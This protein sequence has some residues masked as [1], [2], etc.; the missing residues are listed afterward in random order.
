MGYQRVI[1]SDDTLNRVQDNIT[2]TVN[3]LEQETFSGGNVVSNISLVTGSNQIPHKLG[4]TPTRW[5]QLDL[6]AAITI[7]RTAWDANFIYLTA[8]G[9]AI[10][11]FWVNS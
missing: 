2:N 6:T 11:S 8:S 4:R 10:F 7:F 3:E 5:V 9:P 1:T